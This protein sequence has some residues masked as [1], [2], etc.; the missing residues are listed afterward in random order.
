MYH[1]TAHLLTKMMN[2]NHNDIGDT[3][4]N[5]IDDKL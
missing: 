5:I 3:G 1:D 2:V 4:D